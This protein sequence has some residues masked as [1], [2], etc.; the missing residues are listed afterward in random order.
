MKV[1]VAC[2]FMSEPDNQPIMLVKYPQEEAEAAGVVVHPVGVLS[3]VY[4]VSAIFEKVIYLFFLD[5][6]Y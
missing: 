2:T 5:H 1:F 3:V 4:N 6:S